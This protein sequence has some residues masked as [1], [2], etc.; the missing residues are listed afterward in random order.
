MHAPGVVVWQDWT[1]W[2]DERKEAGSWYEGET[3]S[4]PSV[5][6]RAGM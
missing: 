5:A 4:R 3:V 1:E 6:L 2:V